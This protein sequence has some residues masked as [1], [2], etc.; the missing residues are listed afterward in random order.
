MPI[1]HLCRACG[2][3]LR[4]DLGWCATCYAPVTPFAA[5]PALHEPGTLVG[6]PMSDIKTSRWRAGPTTMGPIGRIGWTVGLLLIFPWWALAVP[7]LSIWRR[8]RVADGTSPSR[9]ER[10]R[11]RHP[12]L[13]RDIHVG[14]TA[15]LVILA[16][17]AAAAVALFLTKQDVDRYLFAVPVLVAGLTIALASWNDL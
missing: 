4:P 3:A 15:R 5:R 9:I 13:G 16:L 17:A 1:G 11:E 7:L 12:A 8:E 14:P 10:F 2:A 6:T